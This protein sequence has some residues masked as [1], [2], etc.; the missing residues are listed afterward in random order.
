M[1]RRGWLAAWL[2][3][4]GH[5]LAWAAGN[6]EFTDDT[7]RPGGWAPPDA[8]VSA[9]EPPSAVAV[10]AYLVD[11][12]T[13]HAQARRMPM[14]YAML[15]KGSRVTH[16][17]EVALTSH[18]CWKIKDG[19]QCRSTVRTTTT[20]ANG[21]ARSTM[22]DVSNDYQWRAGRLFSARLEAMRPQ[23]VAR[24]DAGPGPEGSRSPSSSLPSGASR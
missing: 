2:L 22:L 13:P 12:L 5:G 14:G 21:R 3:L 20:P 23:L 4:S 9:D 19:Y 8:M 11:V 18:Q 6:P 10:A 1:M 15:D 17:V 7:P 24:D 16:T